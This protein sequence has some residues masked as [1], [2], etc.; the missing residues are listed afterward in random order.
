M[1]VVISVS[2]SSCIVLD[3]KKIHCMKNCTKDTLLIELLIKGIFIGDGVIKIQM[4]GLGSVN[5]YFIK[6]T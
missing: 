3:E 4:N 2:I 5:N 1:L 6:T